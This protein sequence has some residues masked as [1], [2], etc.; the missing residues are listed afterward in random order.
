MLKRIITITSLASLCLLVI[1]LNT[2]APST[3]NPFEI[4]LIFIFAY[5]SSLGVVTYFIFGVSY[6]LSYLLSLFGISKKTY[7]KLTFSNSY[8]YAT[9][10]ALAPILL[11]GMQSVG[12][13]NVYGLLL[14]LLFIFIGCLYVSKKIH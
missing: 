10:I 1:F 5:I 11:M 12:V 6:L 8:Y 2:T 7:N 3:A 14:V 9:I 4:L 13:V